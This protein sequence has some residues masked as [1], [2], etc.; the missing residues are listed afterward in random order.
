[1]SLVGR[2][3]QSALGFD[4][5]SIG[6]LAVW[7]DAADSNAFT[8]SGSNVTTWKDK[9][10]RNNHA[11][12]VG[13][14]TATYNGSTGV[15]FGG[16]Q[17]FTLPD[18]AFP[19]G[20]S[21]YAYFLIFTTTTKAPDNT[22]FW[23]GSNTTNQSFGLR[24][25]NGSSGGIRSYWYNNDL[26]STNT[27][28]LNVR[29]QT[30]TFYTAGGQRTIWVNFAL[31]GTDT[32]GPRNQPATSNRIGNLWATNMFYGQMHEIVIYEASLSTGQRQA[33]EGY[34]AKK[35]GLT[36]SL[37]ATHPYK[38]IPPML[39][40]FSPLDVDG[41]ALWLD[42]AD[43]NTLTLS[44]SN[45][46]AWRDKSGLGNHAAPSVSPTVS[47]AAFGGR[48]SL[49]FNGST[50]D[51][52]GSISITGDTLTV[53]AV[54][55]TNSP[56]NGGNGQRVISFASPGASD[57]DSTL[58]CTGINIQGYSANPN[59]ITLVRNN[60][61]VA[62]SGTQH[63]A[64][65]P[66]IGCAQY[67]GA[68]GYAYMNGTVGPTVAASSGTFGIST[69]GIAN[70]STGTV[71]R[72]NGYIGEVLVYSTSLSTTQR[73]QVEAYLASKWGLQGSL[74]STH[75]AKLYKAL[76]VPF[77][78]TQI[79]GCTVWLDGADATTL[80]LVGSNVSQ[81]NDKSGS[82]NHYTNSGTVVYQSNG[83]YFNGSSYLRNTTQTGFP[84]GATPALSTFIVCSI[85]TV[86]SVSTIF[87]YGGVGCSKT[88]Y[89]LYFDTPSQLYGTL[90]CGDLNVNTPITTNTSMLISDVITYTGTS[91]SVTR[92]GW[93]NGAA[94]N[95]PTA[96]ATSVSLTTNGYSYI[97]TYG[98]AGGNG[99]ANSY[100][101]GTINELVFFNRTLTTSQRQQVEGYLAWKWGLLPTLGG[102]NP[103]SG[104]PSTIVPTQIAGC[105]LWLDATDSTTAFQD[106]AG[107][108]RVTATG[109]TVRRWNDKSGRG[110]NATQ[111]GNAP[112]WNSAGY[113][114]F[115]ATSAQNLRLP[116]STL[117]SSA[118]TG[119]YSLFAVMRP[120]TS[121]GMLTIISSGSA[122]T[123]QFNAL[124][125]G[126]DGRLMNLWYNNDVGGGSVPLNTF[127]IASA[128]YTGASRSVFLT[129]STV[130]TTSSTGWAGTISNNCIGIESA[131]NNWAFTGDIGELIVYSNAL[132]TTQ[133]QTLESY[134]AWKWGIQSSLAA[135]TH[136]YKSFKP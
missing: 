70:Q 36:S 23:G 7:L 10:G 18:G 99:Y 50:M 114:T 117:P 16:S 17:Y 131:T 132:S 63:Q 9:S 81:W 51:M 5:G 77:V 20:N 126:S 123:N 79:P 11:T 125:I 90:Y 27:I 86:N 83:L 78:P 71:E 111:S 91:G 87:D 54:Y 84:F 94:M 135:S 46:T 13:T 49:S 107:T 128:I 8:L 61:L 26:E 48:Q 85:Q 89:V 30:S 65:V 22:M 39:R 113:M 69:Y 38:S 57:W 118:A 95:V 21:S 122:G 2:A 119:T 72:L 100:L 64:G 130:N 47:M 41:L 3:Q 12:G 40:S 35:W 106:T 43:V 6:G 15:V 53:I 24:A 96:S 1:M 134:L 97:G 103:Y 112:L 101:T 98:D 58:R 120:T 92:A 75:P 88:A 74:P 80:T 108:S 19:Y 44:G 34:L 42:A 60:V 105:S 28:S 29:Q 56:P 136:P 104:G 133:R 121:G 37:P 31:G 73:Q 45:V 129:G 109:Q 93:L 82:S 14:P 110:C 67:T 4:P 116:D 76:S 127:S 68:A 55:L 115:A 52:G 66:V 59:E 102:G 32:P 33:V 25:G 62:N 124:Q